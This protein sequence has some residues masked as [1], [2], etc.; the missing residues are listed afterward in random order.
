MTDI[1]TNGK[2]QV[3]LFLRPRGTQTVVCVAVAPDG[4]IFK[5]NAES[6]HS[7]WRS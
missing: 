6:R 5:G 7:S 2:P 1:Q 4:S 3:V